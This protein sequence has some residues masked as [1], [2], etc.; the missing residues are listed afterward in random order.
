MYIYMYMYT[1]I[2]MY[3]YACIHMYVYICTYISIYTYPLKNHKISIFHGMSPIFCQKIPT[4]HLVVA[5]HILD[6]AA[7]VKIFGIRILQ[8]L[9]LFL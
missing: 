6:G 8:N 9:G 2:C 4:A 3:I 5:K 1:Y 7:L